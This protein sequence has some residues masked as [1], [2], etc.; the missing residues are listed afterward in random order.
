MATKIPNH[1]PMDPQKAAINLTNKKPWWKTKQARYAIRSVRCWWTREKKIAL[2]FLTIFDVK[3]VEILKFLFE[4]FF[5]W[6]NLVSIIYIMLIETW[7]CWK[8]NFFISTFYL[9]INQSKLE[10]NKEE[11]NDPRV[12]FIFNYQYIWKNFRFNYFSSSL[13]LEPLLSS[14][15]FL[16][17]LLWKTYVSITVLNSTLQIRFQIT[18]T[19]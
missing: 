6:R 3:F 7:G 16:R 15:I 9:Y 11:K 8:N 13:F 10:E 4:K 5:C 19:V 14:I 2:Y 17:E 18:Y 1:H 12:F